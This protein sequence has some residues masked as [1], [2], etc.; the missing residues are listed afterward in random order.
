MFAPSANATVLSSVEV[1]K[2]RALIVKAE[3]HHAAFVFVNVYAPNHGPD[4][5]RLFST[6]VN[7]LQKYHDE[8]IIMGGDFNC[9][10][11]F[12]LD[13]THEEPHPQSSL[14]LKNITTHLDR[15]DTWR[16]KHPCARQYS[17]VRVSNNRVSVARLD[18]VYISRGLSSRLACSNICPVGFTDHHL[19]AMELITSPGE[20]VRS[21]WCFNNKLL[22]DITFCK[23]F[24]VFWQQWKLRK[25]LFSSLKLWWEVG[26]AQ[27]Q[28]FCQQYTSHS[29][30]RIKAAVHN[31]E[32]SI[33]NI[34]GGLH[35][36]PNPNMGPLLQEKKRELSSLLQERVKGALVRSR[37]LHLK[38]MDAPSSFFFNLE[39]STARRKLMTCLKLPDGRVTTSPEEM[40]RH[41][42]DFYTNLFVAEVAA[43][44]VGRSCC[45][46][47]P[48]LARRRRMFWTLSSRWRS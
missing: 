28:V 22:Q 43:A 30:S 24:E 6:L 35:G 7:E 42:V 12:T 15:L 16:V 23:S 14:H 27:I 45:R 29:T 37:F 34:E 10:L 44:S 26:K 41:A 21:Y 20:R 39:R 4:R 19:V 1:V 2:G 36:D 13:R 32:V 47:S 3:I 17:W 5:V 11:D 18:R 9:T 46:S 25:P 40:R 38:D 33:K 31:L 48:S 8:Q